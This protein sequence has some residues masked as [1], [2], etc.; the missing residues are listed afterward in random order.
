VLPRFRRRGELGILR[1]DELGCQCTRRVGKDDELTAYERWDLPQVSG[2]AQAPLR[3]TAANLSTK[4]QLEEQRRRAYEEGCAAGYA[5]G[6]VQGKAEVNARFT[7]AINAL[8]KALQELA[9][10]FDDL[11][12]EVEEQLAALARFA[13][14]QLFLGKIEEEPE[15]IIIMIRAGLQALPSARRD[16]RLEL[17]PDDVEIVREKIVGTEAWSLV[18]DPKI[19]RGGC[20]IRSE[21]SRIDATVATRL[22]GVLANV[23]GSSAVSLNTSDSVPTQTLGESDGEL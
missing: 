9:Q 23:F 5:D 20:R 11:D 15:R 1:F 14:T 7:P 12:C 10:P 18:A 8:N 22:E 13:T 17:H 4:S 16:V 21:A 3:K 2:G 19:Q 6:V